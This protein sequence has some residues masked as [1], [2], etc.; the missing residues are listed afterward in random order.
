MSKQR[1]GPRADERRAGAPKGLCTY[2][3]GNVTPPRR[4][5]CS[6]KCVDEHRIRRDPSYARAQVRQRDHG[7][8][9]LC[10]QDTQVM[11]DTLSGLK[12]AWLDFARSGQTEQAEEQRVEVERLWLDLTGQ[13][14]LMTTWGMFHGLPHLW[15]ADHI[16]PVVE[17]GGEC[18]LDGYRT[19]CLRCHR[20]ETAALA[21]R[22]AEARAQGEQAPLFGAGR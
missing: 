10:R 8:C 7:V 3:G 20:S 22:R 2:C 6:D 9:A 19:L 1:Q 18:G 5:W 13:Q 12:R 4:N 14:R 21:R 15:E 16:V 11:H 17:G